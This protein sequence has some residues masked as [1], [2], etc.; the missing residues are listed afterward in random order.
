MITINVSGIMT[1]KKFYIDVCRINF[2]K[3]SSHHQ[4]YLCIEN[5]AGLQMTIKQDRQA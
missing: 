5:I 2:L 4:V 1:V 3:A